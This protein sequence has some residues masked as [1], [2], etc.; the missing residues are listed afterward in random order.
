MKWQRTQPWAP[1]CEASCVHVNGCVNV[2]ICLSRVFL[3]AKLGANVDSI[4]DDSAVGLPRG[5]GVSRNL[6]EGS[7]IWIAGTCTMMGLTAHGGRTEG[8]TLC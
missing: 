6:V 8:M 5:E 3:R 2:D 1:F 4:L 7:A